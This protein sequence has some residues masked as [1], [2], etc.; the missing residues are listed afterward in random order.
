MWIYNKVGPRTGI[1]PASCALK[2]KTGEI[3][4]LFFKTKISLQRN[5]DVEKINCLSVR[6]IGSYIVT[7]F[8][9]IWVLFIMLTDIISILNKWMNEWMNE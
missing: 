3:F 8:I 1:S 7:K 9:N 2:K 4:S 5:L 6:N